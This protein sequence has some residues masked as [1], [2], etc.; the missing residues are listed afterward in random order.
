[1]TSINII[2]LITERKRPKP[3]EDKLWVPSLGLPCAEV[4]TLPASNLYKFN[5]L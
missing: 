5:V 2:K 4:D 3:M 1:M